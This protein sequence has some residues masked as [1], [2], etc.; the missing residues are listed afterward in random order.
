[1]RG[2]EIA[3]LEVR[4]PLR[5]DAAVAEQLL[6]VA[7]IG[8]GAQKVRG[9]RVVE[10][11]GRDP[12]F[13]PCR[14]RRFCDCMDDAAFAETYSFPSTRADDEESLDGRVSHEERPAEK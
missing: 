5:I 9:K 12:A 1:M 10:R 8:A 6:D 7:E 3:D 14:S 4:V 11:V 2:R 13:D